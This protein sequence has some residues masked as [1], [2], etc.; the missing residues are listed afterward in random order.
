MQGFV[1]FL[2]K[3]YLWPETRGG[4]IDPWRGGWRCKCMGV[5]NSSRGSTPPILQPTCTPMR[6]VADLKRT[7]NMVSVCCMPAGPDW[8]SWTRRPN[9]QRWG[10][11]T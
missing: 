5:E 7:I 4:L 3:N 1:H 11:P 6:S 10:P 9:C 8:R 2:Q